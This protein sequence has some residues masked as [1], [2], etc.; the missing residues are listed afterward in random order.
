[1][2]GFGW[3]VS[4]EGPP[5]F[6]R[7]CTIRCVVVWCGGGRG[8]SRLRERG[9]RV[10]FVRGV[11][12]PRASLMAHLITPSSPRRALS[13]NVYQLH[14]DLQGLVGLERLTETEVRTP[15]AKSKMSIFKALM[16][17]NGVAALTELSKAREAARAK[18]KRAAKPLEVRKLSEQSFRRIFAK[19][20]AKNVLRLRGEGDGV[21]EVQDLAM[22]L[23]GKS[24]TP[25]C[26]H[27]EMLFLYQHA[28]S[29][30]HGGCFG[31]AVAGVAPAEESSAEPA[32]QE[33]RSRPHR[34][35]V[36]KPTPVPSTLDDHFDMVF[37]D[38]LCASILTPRREDVADA[39]FA[40]HT[41]RIAGDSSIEISV[42][43]ARRVQSVQSRRHPPQK[44]LVDESLMPQFPPHPL[45]TR[46]MDMRV[47]QLERNVDLLNGA[48]AAQTTAINE[49]EHVML[50]LRE[51]LA[52]Q[53]TA[54]SAV[55]VIGLSV[56]RVDNLLGRI[57]ASQRAAG[58]AQESFLR[59][60][61]NDRR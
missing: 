47:L 51:A 59:K 41:S 16:E 36:R 5:R 3:G 17:L 14:K 30:Q 28:L 38:D 53:E 26:C 52:Q 48:L 42:S 45:F 6:V 34:T 21:A 56:E 46:H 4:E 7:A 8:R 44:T 60:P 37:D 39:S 35:A 18:E 1:M 13:L 33:A 27:A 55:P 19:V 31:D 9:A 61:H 40:S 20:V 25:A 12:A 54:S 49:A 32:D 2:N 24:S 43:P 11:Y 10:R 50:E 15:T 57:K 22:D 23:F 58:R 29:V